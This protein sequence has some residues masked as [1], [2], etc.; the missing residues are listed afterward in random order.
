MRAWLWRTLR[1]DRHP[2]L[3]RVISV[4]ITSNLIAFT[5]IFFR[6]KNINDALTII[7]R[8]F[9][10]STFSGFANLHANIDGSQLLVS[11]VLIAGLFA[12][13]RFGGNKALW[14][15]VDGTP[16]WLRWSAYYLFA[17][18]LIVL[19]LTNP[20]QKAQQFIYFQF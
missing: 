10:G 11:L 20:A 14:K 5:W 17:L 6:A 12:V 18:V 16:S 9:S 7:Q 4:F 13:E 15:S 1:L 19:I 3:H 2:L 8:I